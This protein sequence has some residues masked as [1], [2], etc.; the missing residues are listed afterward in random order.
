M[1]EKNFVHTSRVLIVEGKYDAARLSHLTDAMILLTDGFAIYKDKKRQQLFKALGRK[2][3]LILLTDSDAAGFRIRTYI[4]NLVGE[5]NVVQAY[6][7]AIHG[8]EKRKPQPG[9]EGLLGVEGVDDALVVKALRDALGPEADAAAPRPAGRQITYTDLYEWGLSGTA[10]SAERKTKLLCALGLPPR[11]SKKELVEA[12]NRLYTFEQVDAL[13]AEV[14]QAEP[15]IRAAIFDL[16]G[17]LLDSM[18]VWSRI[19]VEFLARRGL[20]LPPDYTEAVASRSFVE[21]AKYT[22]ARFGFPD[23]VEEIMAEWT[24]MAREEYAERIGLLPG[25]KETLLRLKQQGLR[26]GVATA[27]QEAMFRP[28]L[29]RNGILDWF[30]AICSVDEVGKGKNSPDVFLRTAEKLGVAPEECVVF[31]D[32]L[33]AVRSAKQAGMKVCAVYEKHSAQSRAEM[34][35]AA[36]WYLE[37]ITDAPEFGPAA[38]H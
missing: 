30:D 2:N 29:A 34:E 37:K 28:C 33:P 10:G 18:D 6:V 27:S 14:L 35:Q 9:K 1:N 36:D 4:T 23:S 25:A 19:D 11:L 7:P 22:I 8:K 5:Q 38:K 20:A 3:G 15:T 26:L 12:L 16:D 13:Q 21:S 32:V 24:E 17:T 31:D